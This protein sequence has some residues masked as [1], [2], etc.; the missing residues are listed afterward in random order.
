MDWLAKN[1]SNINCYKKEVVFTPPSKTRFKFKSTCLGTMPK[2]VSM[3]KARKL[4]RHN[5]CA[6]LASNVNT[7]K[8]ETLLSIVSVV[9]EFSNVFL[10]NF[11]GIPPS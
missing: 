6:I 11:P 4:I 10:E 8:E 7:K 2:V 1:H 9:S 5:A 3:M